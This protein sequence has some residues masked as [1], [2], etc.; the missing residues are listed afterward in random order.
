MGS[1]NF[2]SGFFGLGWLHSS[3]GE[4]RIGKDN[5]DVGALGP[6]AVTIATGVFRRDAGFDMRM[7]NYHSHPG[8]ITGGENMLRTFYPHVVAY[9]EPAFLIRLDA[10]GGQAE[11]LER[12]TTAGGEQNFFDH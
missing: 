8:Y 4:L 7:M 10:G 1:N 6:F 3:K 12:R 5:L 2:V 11:L 9:L